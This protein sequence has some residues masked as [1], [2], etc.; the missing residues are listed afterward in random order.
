MANCVTCWRKT[1][2]LNLGVSLFPT[3]RTDLVLPTE[4]GPRP[5][6]S[7]SGGMKKQA[8]CRSISHN[9]RGLFASGQIQGAYRTMYSSHQVYGITNNLVFDL[10]M[11][12]NLRNE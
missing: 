2:V 6:L 9:I 4:I 5:L 10:L 1:Y 12:F 8:Y 3:K 7:Q 11:A